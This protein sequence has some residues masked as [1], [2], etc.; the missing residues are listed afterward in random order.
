MRWNG[1]GKE[2]FYVGPDARLMSVPIRL[3]SRIEHD[4]PDP[5]F[6]TSLRGAAVQSTDRQQYA[7][8]S[9]GMRILMRADAP[10]PNA[11]PLTLILNWK[12]KP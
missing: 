4:T 9:D 2:L 6:R 10:E 5:L 12:A 11:L 7:I 3:D 8:S 1:N